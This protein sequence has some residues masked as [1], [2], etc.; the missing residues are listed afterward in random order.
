MWSFAST[1]RI[2]TP[3]TSRV[4]ARSSRAI[5][6]QPMMTTRGAGV[7]TRPSGDAGT[8]LVDEST[9]RFGGHAGVTAISVRPDRHAELFVE[10]SATDED[11]VVVADAAVLERLDHDLH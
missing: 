5:A 1:A 11:D 7:V 2:L 8:A 3:G 10:R 4:R 6:P 9:G